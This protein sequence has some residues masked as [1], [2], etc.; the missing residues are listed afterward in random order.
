MGLII[1]IMKLLIMI[2]FHILKN[3]GH[4][5]YVLAFVLY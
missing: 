5:F 2:K 4:T 1:M 3:M